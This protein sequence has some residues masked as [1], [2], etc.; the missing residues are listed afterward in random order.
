MHPRRPRLPD[1]RRHRTRGVDLPRSPRKGWL[2]P[3]SSRRLFVAR[4]QGGSRRERRKCLSPPLRIL[5]DN[6][7]RAGP[8]PPKQGCDCQAIDSLTRR[9]PPPAQCKVYVG[10]TDNES[11]GGGTPMVD[12]ADRIAFAIGPSGPNKVSLQRHSSLSFACS[13]RPRETGRPVH[14]P[15]DIS[16]ECV[17]AHITAGV[18]LQSLRCRARAEPA[19]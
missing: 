2:H 7:V 9:F 15:A 6:A 16:F 1:T 17:T 10:E 14:S 13:A 5:P 12:L 18:P 19:E 4:W 3:S 11:F 8:P